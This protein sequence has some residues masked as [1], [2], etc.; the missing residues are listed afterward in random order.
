M[1]ILPGLDAELAVLSLRL[2]ALLGDVL[3][4]AE[5]VAIVEAAT[6]A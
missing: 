1:Y 6:A 3:K 4:A 5:A 2:T